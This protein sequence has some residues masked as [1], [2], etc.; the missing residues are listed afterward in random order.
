MVNYLEIE[1]C[2]FCNRACSW[3]FFGNMEEFKNRKLEYLDTNYIKKIIQ[4]LKEHDYSGN[5]IV[6]S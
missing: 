6:L 3:C 4:E 5:S 1:T 2:N